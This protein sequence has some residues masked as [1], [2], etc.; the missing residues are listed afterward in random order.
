MCIRDSSRGESTFE[1][2]PHQALP[3]RGAPSGDFG[4]NGGDIPQGGVPKRLSKKAFRQTFKRASKQAAAAT[5]GGTKWGRDY[6]ALPCPNQL[7]EADAACDDESAPC[8][9]DGDHAKMV[10]AVDVGGARCDVGPSDSSSAPW[11][12][13]L[14]DAKARSCLLYT[15]PS[16]RDRTRSRMPSSA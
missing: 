5:T 6:S 2:A 11:W 12:S 7:H 3:G 10:Q 9:A 4:P 13:K 14:H 1:G 15:S 8:L 16:P